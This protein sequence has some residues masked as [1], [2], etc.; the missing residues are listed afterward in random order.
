MNQ[1][2]TAQPAQPTTLVV[3][4]VE[5]LESFGQKLLVSAFEK[6]SIV[7]AP[8]LVDVKGAAQILGI[9]E[10]RVRKDIAESKIVPVR[11]NPIRINP[12]HLK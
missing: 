2:T 6:M 8:E 4:T 1:Q 9:S 7:A 3:M 5:Q 12:N 11:T 10:A